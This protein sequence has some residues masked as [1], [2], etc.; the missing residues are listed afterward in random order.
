MTNDVDIVIRQ[1]ES[2]TL[3]LVRASSSLPVAKMRA[4]RVREQAHREFIK[5]IQRLFLSR[6][7]TVQSVVFSA[8]QTGSGCTF[9]CTRIAE[10]LANQLEEPVCLVDA[11]FR[12]SRINEQF[13]FENGAV[14][15]RDEELTRMRVG[16]NY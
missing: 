16:V 13:E 4:S 5:L 12:S 1:Q 6:S 7:Q 2:S 15:P 14:R 9:V 3:N 10:I 8:V 11:N